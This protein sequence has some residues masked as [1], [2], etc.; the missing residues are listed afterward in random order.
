MSL[1]T[2]KDPVLTFLRKTFK[3]PMLNNARLTP[4]QCVGRQLR[5]VETKMFGRKIIVNNSAFDR[6]CRSGCCEK[7][8]VHLRRMQPKAYDVRMK[9]KKKRE[10]KEPCRPLAGGTS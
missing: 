8:L 5:E 4:A 6:W 9:E 1:Q 3:C 2:A 10:K 7:G